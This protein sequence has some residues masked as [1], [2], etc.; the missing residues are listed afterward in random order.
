M[1]VVGCFSGEGWGCRDG[2]GGLELR[3]GGS[4]G[5][6]VV[7]DCG[8]V[9]GCFSG[10]GWGCCDGVGG[11]LELRVGGSS[12]MAFG[13]CGSGAAASELVGAGGLRWAGP[14]GSMGLWI[15]GLV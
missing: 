3:V 2:V 6:M 1:F 10:E 8:S 5:D 14:I 15:R 13:D 7:G 11:G 4:G 12:E 9:E